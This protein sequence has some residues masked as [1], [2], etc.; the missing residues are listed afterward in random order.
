M[1][2]VFLL[3]GALH[4]HQPILLYQAP[5]VTWQGY[6]DSHRCRRTIFLI[7]D[8]RMSASLN[9]ENLYK[10]DPFRGN[11]KDLKLVKLGH[12]LKYVSEK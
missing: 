6:Q 7:Q 1:D 9:P 3:P 5:K 12:F 11:E 4:N 2:P 10:I 8:N